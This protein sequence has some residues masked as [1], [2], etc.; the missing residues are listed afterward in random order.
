MRNYKLVLLLK[1][2][3][4][5]EAK[6]KVVDTAKGSAGKITGE[7]ITDI[8]ARKLAYPIKGLRNGEYVVVEFSTENIAPD[9]EKK[10]YMQEDIIRHLLVRAD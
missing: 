2:D 3:L 9:F 10:V 1:G 7:K 4:K 6:Q 8:G 5:K